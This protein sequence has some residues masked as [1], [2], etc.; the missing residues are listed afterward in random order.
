MND[1]EQQ[2]SDEKKP[3]VGQIFERIVVLVVLWLFSILRTQSVP[4]LLSA[5]IV[6]LAV[7]GT[8]AWRVDYLYRVGP[9]R[10][11][12]YAEPSPQQTLSRILVQG[13]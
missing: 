4:D 13:P 5:V 9:Y 10:E 12:T 7:K 1:I 6:L 3:K 11:V 8:K 2:R